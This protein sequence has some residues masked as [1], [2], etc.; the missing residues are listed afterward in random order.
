[1]GLTDCLKIIRFTLREES[2]DIPSKLVSLNFEIHKD[3]Q[4]HQVALQACPL[5][6]SLL[7]HVHFLL[8]RIMSGMP[9]K[10]TLYRDQC[11]GR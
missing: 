1:M 2:P 10:A 3:N 4:S 9:K 6:A 7:V 5:S 8:K 11:T